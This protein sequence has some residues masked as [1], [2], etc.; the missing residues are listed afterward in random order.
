VRRRTLGGVSLLGFSCTTE[1]TGFGTGDRFLLQ[2]VLHDG[3]EVEIN[4]KCEV[5]R[6][7]KEK[8]SVFGVIIC[9][10]NTAEVRRRY[11]REVHYFLFL[12]YLNSLVRDEADSGGTKEGAP[13]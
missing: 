7:L 12:R 5:V 8:P 4:L 9:D 1:F 3:Q 11:S 13:A 6:R 10:D 2:S